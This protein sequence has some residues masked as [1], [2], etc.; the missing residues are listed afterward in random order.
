[1]V[2]LGGLKFVKAEHTRI[3]LSTIGHPEADLSK[4]IW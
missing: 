3:I 4:H 1:M 2:Q